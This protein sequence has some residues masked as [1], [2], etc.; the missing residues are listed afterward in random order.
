LI[1]NAIKFGRETSQTPLQI[2]LEVKSGDREMLLEVRNTGH[3]TDPE[4]T[5][6]RG[7]GTGLQNIGRR[8]RGL[9]PGRHE[10]ALDE[11]D[12][13]VRARLRIPY[14]EALDA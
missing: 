7:T 1:E 14:Q 2:E 5:T 3:L 11:H 4:Q 8:L 10:V 12:G 9:Y 6:I 13:W